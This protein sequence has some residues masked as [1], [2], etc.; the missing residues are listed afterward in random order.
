MNQD[1]VLN[2]SFL[3]IFSSTLSQ[4]KVTGFPEITQ[5]LQY[6]SKFVTVFEMTMHDTEGL[7]HELEDDESPIS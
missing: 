5:A 3:E 2:M 4:L 6:L 1:S 7:N